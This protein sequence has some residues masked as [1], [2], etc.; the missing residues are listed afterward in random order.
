MWV[1]GQGH[2]P[3]VL[4]SERPIERCRAGCSEA[5]GVSGLWAKYHMQQIQ[6]KII[7]DSF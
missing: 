7:P 5:L 3:A 1:G 6:C 2:G 4:L